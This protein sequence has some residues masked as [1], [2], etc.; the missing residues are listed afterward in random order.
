MFLNRELP[1][2]PTSKRD[3]PLP[4]PPPPPTS[5]R[6]QIWTIPSFNSFGAY[7]NINTSDANYYTVN[8]YGTYRQKSYTSDDVYD[9]NHGA[10]ATSTISTTGV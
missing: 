10:Y 9:S 7:A 1:P 8:T 3:Q 2:I 5:K 4:P 6:P